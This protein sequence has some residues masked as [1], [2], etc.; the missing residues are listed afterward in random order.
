M[1]QIAAQAKIFLCLQPIDFRKGI[2]GLFAV[3]RQHL[4][5]DPMTG[6][7]FVF[8]NK[9]RTSLKFLFYDGQGFWLCVKRLSK[10]KFLWWPKKDTSLHH[11]IMPRELQ[12]LIWN[13]NPE[14]AAFSNEWRKI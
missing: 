9:S 12:T 2:D 5:I 3:C 13:G 8:R 1:L 14:K 10:G 7:V 11:I 4:D 6:A